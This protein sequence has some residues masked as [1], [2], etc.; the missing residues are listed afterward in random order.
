MEKHRYNPEAGKE[1]TP[2]H[3][4]KIRYHISLKIAEK[5]DF[6]NYVANKVFV[7]SSWFELRMEELK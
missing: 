4:P 7:N 5:S 1:V 3:T 2:V 6:E